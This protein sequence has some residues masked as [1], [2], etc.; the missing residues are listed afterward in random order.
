MLCVLKSESQ[1]IRHLQSTERCG[2]RFLLS[3]KTS[4]SDLFHT[5]KN[6]QLSP[7]TLF[8]KSYF[9]PNCT[10][11]KKSRYRYRV[12][13]KLGKKT[14]RF[15]TLTTVNNYHNTVEQ[16]L[17]I[18]ND[19]NRLRTYLV[20]K[21]GKI[22]YVKCLEVGSDGMVHL[23]VMIDK[24]IPQILIAHA[25]QKY[26]GAYVVKINK[27]K[28]HEACTG[29]ITSYI[30]KST[31]DFETN[32]KFYLYNKRRLTFSREFSEENNF[33]ETYNLIVNHVFRESEMIN[34]L[35]DYVVTTG[36]KFHDFDFQ[37]LPP[38]LQ[39]FFLTQFKTSF[40]NYIN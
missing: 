1:L 32:K 24:Y 33:E 31:N 29:Y 16:L 14:W 12:K 39:K 37:H 2:Q 3:N 8:C 30:S 21:V 4:Y 23:H 22:A 36:I 35:L 25:W 19:W 7:L 10:S 27:A 13:K 28:S 15:L 9:C 5:V 17:R 18:N 20:K 26:C 11:K 6:I 34:F 40:P 38:P